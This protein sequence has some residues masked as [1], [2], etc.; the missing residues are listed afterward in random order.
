MNQKFQVTGMTCSACSAF[1]EKTVGKLSGVHSV[2]VNLLAN[3]MNVDYDESVLSSE[4][5]IHAVESAGYGA[6]LFGEKGKI[7]APAAGKQ[8]KDSMKFRL[9]F[10]VL[11]MLPLFYISMG[12]MLGVPLPSFLAGEA[13]ILSWVF[14]QFLLCLPIVFVN[15]SYFQNGFRNLWKKSPNMDSLIAIGSASALIY[16]IFAIYRIGY[17]LGH[18]NTELVHR[19]SMDVYFE[20]AAMI[21]TL[22]TVGKY[23]ESGSK[24]K[25]SDA[26]AKL[27]DLAPKT[28]L[29]ETPEGEREIPLEQVAVGDTVIVKP[30][31]SIPVD[32]VVLEGFSSVDESALT[33]E[34]I[35]AEKKPGDKVTGACINKNGYLKFRAEKVGSETALSQIVQLVEEASASKAPIAKLADKVSGVFVPVVIAIALIAFVVWLCLG[36]SFEFAMSIGIAVLVISCP[37]ALGLATPTAIMVGMGKGAEQ[38]ILI[39]SAEV[40]E[41]AHHIQ[42]VVLDKTGTI[43][44][45][46]PYVTDVVTNLPEETLLQIAASL[47]KAS[48]HP[49]AEAIVQEAEKRKLSLLP[50]EHFV[51]VAGRGVQAE[52]NGKKYCAG[53]IAFLTENDILVSHLEEKAEK[54]SKEGKT[55]LFFADEEGVI[56]VIGV[57]DIVKPTSS[58]AVAELLSMGIDVVMLTGDNQRTA[59]AIQEQVGIPHVIS[60]VMPQDKEA[61]IRKLQKQGKMVAM[62][63]DGVNDAPALARA[64]VGIAIGAGTDIALESAD[65][66]LMKNDLRE[67]VTAIELSKAVIRN[68]KQNLFWAL[69]YN[70]IGIPLAAGVF[71]AA[72]QWKLNPMFGAAAMSLSSFCVVSNALRLKL[73]HKKGE[74]TMEKK[75]LIEGMSCSHCSDRVEK[76]LNELEGVSATVDLAAKTATITLQ[77]PV[78]DQLLIQTVSDA[79]YTVVEVK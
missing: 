18:G 6:A 39:K 21:L 48:E 51:S 53:N 60:Q 14:T 24:K 72:F 36:Y 43:T 25:T 23:L 69:L 9:W 34:S 1:V 66:V 26:I 45:G 29:I 32:G 74:K 8:K 19:Y 30:G 3:Q 4:T 49:L 38:G 15:R 79:G 52:L 59:K 42:T 78:S 20:T 33:G 31:Q 61:E 10:S 57:S 50:A 77:K 27:M 56:G 76:V 47:E 70:S 7:K 37:C 58:K 67:V 68:I 65:V 63:G 46:K 64:D 11:F 54:L 16:G 5:I 75:M 73:F 71:Y 28:A 35:P 12:H 55:P 62:V 22:I 17:G 13:N 2:Q 44:E 40:L 41:T